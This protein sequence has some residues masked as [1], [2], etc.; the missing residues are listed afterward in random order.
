MSRHTLLHTESNL[1]SIYKKVQYGYIEGS[2][3]WADIYGVFELPTVLLMI[4]GVEYSF[5]R[6]MNTPHIDA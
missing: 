4:E 6:D 3:K 2:E 1:S 5:T